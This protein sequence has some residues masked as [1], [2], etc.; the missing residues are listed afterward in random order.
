[1]V[2]GKQQGT[3]QLHFRVF[4]Y[5]IKWAQGMG[6][7]RYTWSK[8]VLF[9]SMSMRAEALGGKNTVSIISYYSM[10]PAASRASRRNVKQTVFYFKWDHIL[11]EIAAFATF[12]YFSGLFF[13]LMS[14]DSSFEVGIIPWLV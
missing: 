13:D 8:W 5:S 11:I 14:F 2:Y 12:Y 10:Y 1:M 4:I 3:Q 7:G 9:D 6:I